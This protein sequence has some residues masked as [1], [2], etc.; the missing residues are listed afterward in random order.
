VGT[1][2]RRLGR[3]DEAE[4]RYQ[5]AL[6]LAHRLDDAEGVAT[7]TNNLAELAV[8]R[9]RPAEAEALAQKALTL[10]EP[11]GRRTLIAACCTNLARALAAQGRGAEGRPYAERAVNILTAL[12]SPDLPGAQAALAACAAPPASPRRG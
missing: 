6:A 10:A 8:A 3:H 11:I 12:R 5:E 9:G 7:F 1:I 2:L 4:A